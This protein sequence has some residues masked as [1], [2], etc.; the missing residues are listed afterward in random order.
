VVLVLLVAIAGASLG[1]Q[2]SDVEPELRK[3]DIQTLIGAALLG[4]IPSLAGAQAWRALLGGLHH[5]PP[6]AATTS[7]F[8]VAQ[9]GKYLPGS[10]WPIVI[11]GELAT[12]HG[13]SRRRAASASVVQIALLLDAGA[14]IAL[15]CL[16]ATQALP[17]LGTLAL[18]IAAVFLLCCLLPPVLLRLSSFVLR[19][20]RREPVE[21]SLG[22]PEMITAFGWSLVATGALGVHAW[23]LG[24][25]LGDISIG[26]AA[27]GFLLA[28]AA[29]FLVPILPAGGGVRETILYASLGAPLGHHAALALAAVSRLLLVVVDLIVG[30][31]AA[32]T[33]RRARAEHPPADVAGAASSPS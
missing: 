31:I 26:R 11:Q 13:I 17:F 28:W 5:A 18:A 15:V 16:I 4:A 29:G 14:L 6:R 7:A 19:R 33:R 3:I 21:V 25:A 20:L 32:L 30:A 8:C 9:L 1:R 27:G 22:W 2:W 12:S 10:L 23:L 24:R